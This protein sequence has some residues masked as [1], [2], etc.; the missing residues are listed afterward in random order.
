[1]N[2]GYISVK[3]VNDMLNYCRSFDGN[4]AIYIFEKWFREQ[5]PVY[6]KM[7][8]W[9]NLNDEYDDIIES[10][11]SCCDYNGNYKWSYCP[12]CGAKMEEISADSNLSHNK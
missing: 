11:C 7:G 9:L 5:C 8:R 10:V 3:A 4:D 12:N 1:M 6:P 2:K